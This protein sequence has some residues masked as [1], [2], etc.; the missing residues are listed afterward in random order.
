MDFASLMKSKISASKT[1]GATGKATSNLEP[2]DKYLRRSEVE[3]NRESKYLA[4]QAERE[5]ARQEK[6]SRKR[7]ADEEEAERDRIREEKKRKLAEDS[8]ARREIEEREE[9]RKRRKR[10]G[11]PDL[12]ES[13]PEADESDQEET[14]DEEVRSRLRDMDE[15]EELENETVEGRLKRYRLLKKSR[16]IEKASKKVYPGPIPTTLEPLPGSEILVPAKPPPS[17]AEKLFLYRQLASYFTLLLT[18]WAIKLSERTAEV[19]ESSSGRAATNAMSQATQHLKPLYQKLETGTIEPDILRPL[20]EIVH[21]AQQRRYVDANDA[22]LR[23]SIG[24][25]AWPIG[26]TMVGI[27]ERSAREK[28]SSGSKEGDRTAHI[29]QDEGTRKYLQAVKRCLSFAQTR[30]P[31]S[32]MRQL[33]G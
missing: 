29:M 31:P 22:Y 33:M 32:D 2:T 10:L 19:K 26:V 24:K 18:E 30:W 5:R 7:K 21:A 1:G 15:D 17:E 14:A 6:E 8:K 28:L 23:L 27:H 9:E 3:K 12:I 11:L 16:Q 13:K 25:A 20:V 4:D